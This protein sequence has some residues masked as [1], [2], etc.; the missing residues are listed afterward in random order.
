MAHSPNSVQFHA[1]NVQT[2]GGEVSEFSTWRVQEIKYHSYSEQII[3]ISILTFFDIKMIQKCG[4]E[5][6]IQNVTLIGGRDGTRR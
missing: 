2:F 6:Y 1:I 5:S 4:K 3:N